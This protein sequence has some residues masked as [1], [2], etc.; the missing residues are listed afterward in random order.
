MKKYAED[1]SLNEKPPRSRRLFQL[2][3]LLQHELGKLFTKMVEVP[4]NVLVSIGQIQIT[5]DLEQAEIKISV[6]PFDRGSEILQLLK[7]LRPELQQELN[8]R[9]RTYRVP[10][11]NFSLDNTE[12]RADRIEHLLDS[13]QK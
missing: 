6:L 11:I 4:P 1:I 10:K 2:D 9:L 13:L 5:A 12:E 7:Q 3:S 8:Q